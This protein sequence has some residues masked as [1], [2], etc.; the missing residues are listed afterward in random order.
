MT[1]DRIEEIVK[2]VVRVDYEPSNYKRINELLEILF[3]AHTFT[4]KERA[5]IAEILVDYI[6][7][8]VPQQVRDACE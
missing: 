6:R 4:I 1:E 7:Y 5:E 8:D 3:L 2:A